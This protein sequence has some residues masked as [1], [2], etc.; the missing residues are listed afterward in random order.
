[1]Y[2]DHGRVVLVSSKTPGPDAVM[3]ARHPATAIY[4]FTAAKVCS[5]SVRDKRSG[6]PKSV[7]CDV[8]FL[9][10]VVGG[11]VTDAVAMPHVGN[12]PPCGLD[13]AQFRFS[14]GRLTG[15]ASFSVL[16]A[17]AVGASAIPVE[18]ELSAE[19]ADGALSG[20]FKGTAGDAATSGR[21]AGD[22]CPRATVPSPAKVWLRIGAADDVFFRG[23]VFVV[24][25]LVEG[26]AQPGGHHWYHKGKVIGTVDDNGLALD[27]LRLSG[28]MTSTL[29]QGG[30]CY[31]GKHVFAIDARLLGN[32]YLVGSATVI[33][34]GKT[35]TGFVRGGL[36]PGDSPV[37]GLTKE[38]AALYAARSRKKKG[39]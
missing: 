9:V 31:T 22:C 27:G 12:R 26:K 18:L 30:K 13:T 5:Y 36:V 11:K 17:R 33:A 7:T 20:T 28:Q 21:L 2:Q 4:R 34:D 19:A 1:M 37:T 10:D 3:R 29:E 38:L 15:E 14:G 6:A 35:H 8:S 24:F 39:Q 25:D 23:H 16:D 32:R